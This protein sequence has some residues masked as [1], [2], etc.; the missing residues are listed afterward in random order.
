MSDRK[1]LICSAFDNTHFDW[2]HK[3]SLNLLA[4]KLIT[5]VGIK[6]KEDQGMSNTKLEGAIN[7]ILF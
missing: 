1:D 3:S 7:T 4:I 2:L 6:R 5:V